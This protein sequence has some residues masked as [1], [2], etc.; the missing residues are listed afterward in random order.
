MND[1]FLQTYLCFP[2]TSH[3]IMSFMCAV[4]DLTWQHVNL[5]THTHNSRFP[6]L[7]LNFCLF[8]Y[9][10]RREKGSFAL[11]TLAIHGLSLFQCLNKESRIRPF[12]LMSFSPAANL[13]PA[14]YT[15]PTGYYI[16][17]H[18]TNQSHCNI[19]R[20]ASRNGYRALHK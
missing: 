14:K 10:F 5:H 9:S 13:H 6:F 4:I 15:E 17:Q 20:L 12:T 3:L 19:S 7:W 2:S 1:F 18:F 8:S 11:T 16:L